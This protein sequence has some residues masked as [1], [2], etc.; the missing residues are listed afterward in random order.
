MFLHPMLDKLRLLKLHGMLAGL[1]DQA[2]LAEASALS[3][4]ERLGLLVDREI[5]V[6]ENHKLD[7]LFGLKGS[8]PTLFAE[9]K[10]VL[11]KLPAAQAVA[12]AA[13]FTDRQRR[14]IRVTQ[15][16]EV[17]DVVEQTVG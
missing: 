12:D 10:R 4:E 11:E 6:R 3:F 8:Q 5:T 1:A 16:G 15:P 13:R 2:A 14:G 9:A 7:Y 17:L